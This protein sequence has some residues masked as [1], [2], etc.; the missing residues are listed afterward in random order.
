MI[1]PTKDLALSEWLDKQ[2]GRYQQKCRSGFSR[3]M[4]FIQEK[5]GWEHVTGDIILSRHTENRKADDKKVK[6]FFDDLIPPFILWIESIGNSHNSA[7]VQAATVKSFF[8]YHREP[9]QVQGRIR[10][11]ETKKRYHAYNK[12]ELVKMV[13]VGD[14][15]EKAIILLGVQLGIRVGDFVSLKR[16]PILEAYQDSNG[17]FPLEFEVET[18]KEGVISI[19]HISKE[20]YETLQLYWKSVP[21]SEYVFPSNNGRAYISEQRAND[22][23]K[24]TWLKAFP[25]R[26]DAKI[27][28]HEL[29]SYKISALSNAGINSWHVQKMTGKKVS[30][31]INTYLTGVNLKD[32][33]KKSEQ[34]LTPTQTTNNNHSRFEKE[35]ED[36][37]G[38][39]TSYALENKVLKDRQKALE[40]ETLKMEEQKRAEIKG[41]QKRMAELEQQV[42]GWKQLSAD[43]EQIRQYVQAR[44]TAE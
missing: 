21:E 24:N 11:R 29:R 10:F 43:L 6:Y 16:K 36:L 31:D 28:F 38:S 23:L 17:D 12:D 14:L 25:E 35:I 13:Q 4:R 32:D 1:E 15:E 2:R 41:L 42:K 26:S 22:V 39:L 33:F 44:K 34:A 19:G 7:V 40:E 18:E 8:K 30:P 37:R 27:R 9:L 20:V 3:F 5:Y